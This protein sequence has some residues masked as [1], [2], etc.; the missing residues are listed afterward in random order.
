MA[1]MDKD[2]RY[3]A[4]KMSSRYTKPGL[5]EKIKKRV[6][7]G[8][9]GGKPGQWSARKA[10]I[11]AKEYEKAGGG[12]KKGKGKSQKSLSKWT[13]QKWTTASGKPSGKTGEAYA[14][15]KTIDAL[16]STEKGRK[17]LS[18]ANRKKREASKKGKQ[19]ASH[20]LHKGKKR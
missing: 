2:D 17:K 8:S 18:E 6:T 10:Q 9:K 7:A 12:Y 1:P 14:P 16:K 19:F 20:G 4:G 13:K 5:R 15:K 11:V 3:L